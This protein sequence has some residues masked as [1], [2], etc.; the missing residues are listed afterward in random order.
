LMRAMYNNTCDLSVSNNIQ[1]V[2]LDASAEDTLIVVNG[3]EVGFAW[4][5]VIVNPE[6]ITGLTGAA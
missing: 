5:D 1:G 3:D 4:V 2:Q 6:K